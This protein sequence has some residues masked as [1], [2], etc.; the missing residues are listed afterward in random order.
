MSIAEKLKSCYGSNVP[1]F[2]DEICAVMS[3]YSRPRVYQLIAAAIEDGSLAR[4][5][6][7]VYYVPTITLLGKSKLDPIKVIEKKYI[8][9]SKDVYGF[10]SG[11][12]LLNSMG[13][14]TQ[15]P[16]VIEIVTNNES[17]RRREISIGYQKVILRRA[18][19]EINKQNINAFVV[20][21][22][23]NQLDL[24]KMDAQLG[25]QGVR[26]YISSN[27]LTA[28]QIMSY[29][30]QFPARATKNIVECGIIYGNA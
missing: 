22:L 25:M 19:M 10:Y 21:E 24:N 8:A 23:F 12:R 13:L 7:G 11:I 9:D 5:D 14:T 6:N 26:D 20:L 27:G 4:F 3:D 2:V 16:N 18:R 15:V 29:A 30:K 1:I 28:N 17:M